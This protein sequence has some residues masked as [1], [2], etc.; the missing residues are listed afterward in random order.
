M[1]AAQLKVGT[2]ESAAQAASREGEAA[3][4]ETQ[5]L[6]SALKESRQQSSISTT[7]VTAGKLAFRTRLGHT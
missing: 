5:R 4:Q 2:L 1:K 7:Q 3:T 6:Q